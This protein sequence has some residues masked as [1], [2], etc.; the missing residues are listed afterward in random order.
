M[1]A[2]NKPSQN[3]VIKPIL[4]EAMVHSF[5]KRLLSTYMPD[6]IGSRNK[7]DNFAD[8]FCFCFHEALIVLGKLESWQGTLET[9]K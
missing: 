5:K 2:K 4:I 3:P 1:K 7:A 8:Y 6:G 9:G